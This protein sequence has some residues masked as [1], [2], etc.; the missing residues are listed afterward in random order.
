MVLEM[1]TT[2]RHNQIIARIQAEIMFYL[3]D[4]FK[5]KRVLA[6]NEQIALGYFGTFAEI[7]CCRLIDASND[8]L[9][10]SLLNALQVIQ[11]DYMLFKKNNYI[12]NENQTRI[13]GQPDLVIE[14]WSD[15]NLAEHKNFKKFLY[16]TSDKTE[17]WYL[18]QTNN[19]V[20]CWIG[21]NR[22]QDQTL[23]NILITKDGLKIDLRY[24]SL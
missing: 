19:I 1:G 17:H 2:L 7:Y 4:L 3:N 23:E 22:L 13:A 11:P 15:T 12:L 24:L 16:S 21:Q 10:N 9:D 18:N 20:E 14:V 6:A 8:F 5:T